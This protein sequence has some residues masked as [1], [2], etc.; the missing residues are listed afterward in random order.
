MRGRAGDDHPARMEQRAEAFEDFI[1]RRSCGSVSR[2][3]LLN[4]PDHDQRVR[5]DREPVADDDG[6]D[7]DAVN[8]GPLDSQTA[9]PNQAVGQGVRI[10]G[11]LATER[12]G[13]QPF[14]VQAV[15]HRRGFR[16]RKRG[17]REHDVVQRFGQHAAQPEHDARPEVWVAH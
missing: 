13:E 5:G 15:D 9:Q 16:G 10:D 4:R 8:V 17:D 1:G 6:I 7:V 14:R 2:F 3:A 11:R 12:V